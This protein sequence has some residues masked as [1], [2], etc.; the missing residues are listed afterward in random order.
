MTM[1]QRDRIG[2][3]IIKFQKDIRHKLE[4]LVYRWNGNAPAFSICWC[5]RALF[6]CLIQFLYVW[7]TLAI[8]F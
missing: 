2:N 3:R 8:T 1:Q 5:M 7:N 6:L 4:P